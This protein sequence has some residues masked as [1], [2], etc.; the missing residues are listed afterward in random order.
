MNLFPI[1]EDVAYELGR[2]EDLVD[3]P[4]EARF[5]R[6]CKYCGADGLKWIRGEFEAGSG[7]VLAYSY[8]PLANK[9]HACDSKY[10]P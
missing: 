8:G 10:Q 6:T 4:M 1:P 2:A 9:L 3:E 5:H 7:W